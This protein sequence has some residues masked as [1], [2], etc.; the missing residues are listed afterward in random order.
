MT[1]EKIKLAME[2]GCA[3]CHL[4]YMAD[5]TRFA[6]EGDGPR[7]NDVAFRLM[8]R[9]ESHNAGFRYINPEGVQSLHID[10]VGGSG[11]SYYLYAAAGQ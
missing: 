11:R 2:S 3:F 5:Q 7:P 10:P 4:L 6:A 9:T 1:R 8:I